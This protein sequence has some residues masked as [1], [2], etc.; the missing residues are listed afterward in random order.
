MNR[1]VLGRL[2][3]LIF[4][5]ALCV[6]VLEG[7]L[8]LLAPQPVVFIDLGEIYRYDAD[9]GY[10]LQPNSTSQ[11]G[12]IVI[13]SHGLRDYEIPLAKPDG[14]FRI[15]TLGDSYTF[16]AGPLESIYP[17]VLER[18]L[19]EALPD[20]PPVQVIS[21]GVPGWGTD[22]ETIWLERDGF[23]YEPDVVVLGFYVGN[24]VHDN[25]KLAPVVPIGGKLVKREEASEYETGWGRLELEAAAIA[26]RSHV[27]RFVSRR[28]AGGSA[29]K[30]PRPWKRPPQ[31]TTEFKPVTDRMMDIYAWRLNVFLTEGAEKW[32]DGAWDA[33][34]IWFRRLSSE[35][36]ERRIPLLVLIIPEQIQVNPHLERRLLE[37]L[38]AEKTEAFQIDLPQMRLRSILEEEGIAYL[39]V[40]EPFRKQGR[41]AMLYHPHNAHWNPAGNDLGARLLLAELR[42]MQL[43]P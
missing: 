9:L 29:P 16:G 33:T 13:N 18:L 22:E 34:Q 4:S 5:T 3:L 23:D 19:R 7:G 36:E 1:L 20:G 28:I 24:D 15:L 17:K 38:G 42:R 11:S 14:Y 31:Q 25:L 37:Q 41:E 32:I 35:L 8:R 6:A 40:L 43:T 39:D 2:A 30:K 26:H 12:G 27:Y 21:A 10:T